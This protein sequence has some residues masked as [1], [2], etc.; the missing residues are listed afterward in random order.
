M[1]SDCA[2]GP[3][4]AYYD[5]VSGVNE[6]VRK[7]PKRLR[8]KWAV[9]CDSFKVK[10]NM[11]HAPFMFFAQFLWNLARLKNEPSFVFDNVPVSASQS[12]SSSNQRPSNKANR[13][14]GV[15]NKK[16]EVIDSSKTDSSNTR[17]PIH[18][19]NSN[20]TLKDCNKFR[21]KSLKERKDY[22]F[23]NGYCLRCCGQKRHIRKNC[24]ETV[25]CDIH[26]CSSSE[27][28]SLLHPDP[29]PWKKQEGEQIGEI[30]ASCT[31][32]CKTP[33]STIKSCAKMVLV[34]VY[35]IKQ[36]L[37]SRKVYCMIDDQ[38]NKS[39]AT[40][41][42]FN[43]FEEYGPD[44]EYVM[45]S[46]AG[47]FVT[48]GHKAS[49]YAVKSLDESCT[50]ELPCLIECNDIPNSRSEIPSPA[51]AQAYSH[52]NDLAT[53][54]P[55]VDD[56]AE[57]EIL[58]GRDLI[59][60]HY[61]LD[62]RIGGDSLPF[63]QKLPLG[64]VIIGD[65][66]LGRSHLPE[67]ISV[68]KTSVLADGRPTHLELCES[69]L[70]INTTDA[71]FQHTRGD[72]KPGLSVEDQQ[73]LDIM[74]TDFQKAHTGQWQAPLPFRKDRPLLP[75]NKPLA[76]R[77]VKSFDMNLRNKPV[78]CEQVIDFMQKL[79]SNH[80]AEIAPRIPVSLERW[81]IPIFAVYHPKKPDSVRVVFDS[82]AKFQDVSLNNVLLQG[83]DLCNSLLGILLRFHRE[84]IAVTMDVEQM[85]YSFKGP[86]DHHRYLRFLWH[87][88]NDLEQPLVEYQMTVHVFG[89]S[90]SPAV[91]TYGIRKAVEGSSKE[92]KNLVNNNFYVDD[93]LLSCSSEDKAI[94]LVLETKK[95]L[96]NGGNIR[97]HKF[98]SNSRSVL[99]SFAQQDLSKNLKDLNLGTAILPM[100]RSLGLLWDTDTDEFIFKV[101]LSEKAYTKRG[102]LSTNK[103]YLLLDL[104]NLLLLKVNCCYVR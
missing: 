2:F 20:H 64:W 86:E 45:S 54:I 11:F 81:Y 25:K 29:D 31:Q 73:F 78:K 13:F 9:E 6:F 87:L 96:Q 28:I 34:S 44:H 49:G 92:V 80:H 24:K 63:G 76:L 46:C 103:Q 89:N 93:G 97:L 102:L 75:D 52:L 61:V 3:A 62:Q 48:S 59:S 42:F 67:I 70:L 58:I 4:F 16:T 100:Q 71:I 17:C 8:E 95:A 1:K 50:F 12:S 33:Q 60:A 21:D 7:L 22:L 98:A 94:D 43:S 26:V 40:S 99:N 65:V 18:G 56:S 66:C 5:T 79:I 90:P 68:S 15:S 84:K 74:E 72:K 91:A 53:C 101:N 32:V 19:T 14:I 41:A 104:L 51:V 36:P 30:E 55:E 82:S 47:K 38:S 77:R 39:L 27:H 57:I 69:D 85:F 23:K 35:P 37:L 83:P 10:N 88:N